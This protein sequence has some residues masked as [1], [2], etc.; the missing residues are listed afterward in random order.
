MYISSLSMSARCFASFYSVDPFLFCGYHFL[1]CRYH[2]ID[3]IL[4]LFVCLFVFFVGKKENINAWYLCGVFQVLSR[5]LTG[6]VST[7]DASD[8]RAFD[9]FF[10][11][12]TPLHA[13]VAAS[14][15]VLYIFLCIYISTSFV[16]IVCVL[17]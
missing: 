9:N 15:S 16:N 3:R 14:A 10:L 5:G 13:A 1:H 17:S 11:R 8:Y 4:F 12:N 7:F 6:A 2:F